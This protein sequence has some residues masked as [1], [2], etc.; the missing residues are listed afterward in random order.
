MTNPYFDDSPVP[1]EHPRLRAW[2]SYQSATRFDRVEIE[3]RRQLGAFGFGVPTLYVDFVA[4]DGT[5][6]HQ[7]HHAWDV[8]LDDWLVTQGARA[9]TEDNEVL[10]TSLRVRDHLYPLLL[11]YGEGYFNTL[12]VY[13]TRSGPLAEEEPVRD[14]LANLRRE[15]APYD[16][17]T[18]AERKAAVEAVFK[19]IAHELTGKLQYE[20]PAAERIL[21]R[22][23]A[24]YLDERFHVTERIRHFGR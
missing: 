3:V 21:A 5:P 8:E 7:D 9:R 19:R 10:R 15:N 22:A 13:V 18:L 6:Q 23:V 12:V 24:M 14:L 16:G 17:G 4:K 2:R 1:V 20:R 11:R